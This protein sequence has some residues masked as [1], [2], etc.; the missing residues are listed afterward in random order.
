MILQLAHERRG[1]PS[2]LQSRG[3]NNNNNNNYYYN[4]DVRIIDH[5]HTRILADGMF[6]QTMDIG[7]VVKAA[8]GLAV[9]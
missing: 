4:Y 1:V 6:G 9:V 3:I 2:T 8:F 7:F 5:R